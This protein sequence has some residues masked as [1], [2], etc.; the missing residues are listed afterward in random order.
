MHSK[1]DMWELCTAYCLVIQSLI[2][3]AEDPNRAQL[4]IDAAK[5]YGN[6]SRTTNLINNYIQEAQNLTRQFS[7]EFPNGNN[8]YFNN[9]VY[10]VRVK[11]EEC[12]VK[13]AFILAIY[14][15]MRMNTMPTNVTAYDWAI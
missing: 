5:N 12:W 14:S 13:H 9:L 8:D 1:T 3:N 10:D 4:A 11:G 15:L 7:T 6:L 2:F